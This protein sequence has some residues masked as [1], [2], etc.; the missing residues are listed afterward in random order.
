MR[1]QEGNSLLANR[2]PI[3]YTWKL[4]C[5][6]KIFLWL[7][8]QGQLLTKVY[9]AKWRPSELMNCALCG[10]MPESIEHL[11][12]TCH[13]AVRFWD[14]FGTMAGFRCQF[15]NLNE[16]WEVMFERLIQGE[17]SIQAR[18]WCIVVPADLWALWRAR[19]ALIFRNQT[20]YM[21]NL[22]EDS[23]FLLKDWGRYLVG[24]RTFVTLVSYK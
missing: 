18:F 19:N 9:R 16:L 12:L 22:W 4:P 15:H 3:L 6:I 20:F 17:K 24:A 2:K 23:L 7:V 8:L 11:L 10:E 5:K 1:S 13:R 14:R 21:E